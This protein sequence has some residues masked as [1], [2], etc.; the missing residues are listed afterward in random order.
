MFED[1]SHT[2]AGRSLEDMSLEE[3]AEKIQSLEAQIEDCKAM[4]ARKKA[5]KNAADAI[6]GA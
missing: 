5:S 3:L 4:I 2:A 6:F 1:E